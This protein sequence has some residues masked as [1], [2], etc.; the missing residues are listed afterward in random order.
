LE[1]TRNPDYYTKKGQL[2]LGQ[3]FKSPSAELPKRALTTGPLQSELES[4]RKNVIII[5]S[6]NNNSSKV[7]HINENVITDTDNVT[8]KSVSASQLQTLCY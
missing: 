4:N 7:V 2:S 5:N 8:Q 3:Y 1:T 6:N